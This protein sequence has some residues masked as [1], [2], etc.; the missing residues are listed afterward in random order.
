MSRWKAALIHLSISAAIG[1]VSA[2]LIFGVWYPAPYGHAAGAGELILLLLGV[3]VVL[4]PLL[5][6]VVFKSGKKSLPFDLSVIAVLQTCAFCFGMSI[7]VRARPVFIVGAIDRFVLVAADDLDPADL[8][9]GTTPEY[10]AASWTGPVVTNAVMPTNPKEKSD[11]VDSGM[12][13]KDIER[14]PKY[15]VDYP[16]QASSLLAHAKPAE[17]LLRV[18]PE[19]RHVFESWLRDHQRDV[20]TIVWLPLSAPRGDLTVLLDRS[21]SRILDALPIEPW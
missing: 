20:N 18:H 1:L 17:D 11:L 6:L 4:G 2:L 21:S 16:A 5:T 12:A 7:V 3:D 19:A 15:Y 9:K 13:G 8:A 14:F 10:R